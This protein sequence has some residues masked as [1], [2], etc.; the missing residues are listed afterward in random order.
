ME[1]PGPVH[2]SAVNTFERRSPHHRLIGFAIQLVTLVMAGCGAIDLCGDARIKSVLSPGRTMQ[3]VVFER[4]CGAT[5]ETS[6]QLSILRSGDHLREV[7]GTWVATDSGNAAVFR[8]ERG[9]AAPEIDVLWDSP[10][11]LRVVYDLNTEL[12]SQK[13]SV[14]GITV[15]YQRRP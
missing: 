12:V 9:A 13:G 7:P 5:T 10:T 2:W 1:M 3:A 6:T 4:G 14:K 11:S 8:S 15:T